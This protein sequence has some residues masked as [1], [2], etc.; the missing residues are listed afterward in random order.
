[1]SLRGL[2]R[3]RSTRISLLR[4]PRSFRDSILAW[5]LSMIIIGVT[6][7]RSFGQMERASASAAMDDG[8]AC[9]GWR[10]HQG[11][12]VAPEKE[13]SADDRVVRDQCLRVRSDRARRR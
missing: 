1:M 2:I 6:T 7:G 9:E 5:A 3:H 13:R 4:S 12:L 11:T 8:R 10:K